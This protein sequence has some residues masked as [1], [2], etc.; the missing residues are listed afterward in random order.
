MVLPIEAQ[1]QPDV[2]PPVSK[3][4]TTRST[5]TTMTYPSTESRI[6]SDDDDHCIFES[7]NVSSSAFAPM[8]VRMDELWGG[9]I[10]MRIVAACVNAWV[11]LGRR[12]GVGMDSLS[13]IFVG[14]MRDKE[15]GRWWD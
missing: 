7:V 4:Q 10:G 3:S 6:F 5:M 14:E 1:Q 8:W 13:K 12:M 11:D 2:I 15:T 9:R